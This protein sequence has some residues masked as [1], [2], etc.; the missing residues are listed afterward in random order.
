VEQGA[1]LFVAFRCGSEDIARE[2]CVVL[3]HQNFKSCAG[4]GEV[5]AH[6][7]DGVSLDDGLNP[8]FCESTFGQLGLRAIAE[9]L[10]DNELGV[11]HG[12]YY[13]R[14]VCR[15]AMAGGMPRCSSTLRVKRPRRYIE[16]L[17]PEIADVE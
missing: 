1:A 13:M 14:E 11:L 17:T 10:D 15:P 3:A 4:P 5:L 9:G 16:T 6:S 8:G 12:S 2:C 7:S